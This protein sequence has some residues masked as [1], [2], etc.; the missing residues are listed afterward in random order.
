MTDVPVSNYLIQ[1]VH[2]ATG[3]VVEW[4][5]GLEVERNLIDELV[6]RVVA[7]GVGVGRT[8]AHVANDVRVALKELLFD[9]KNQV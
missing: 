9:L 2:R 4:A 1:V 7:K 8:Q 3:K 5:P 6:Q